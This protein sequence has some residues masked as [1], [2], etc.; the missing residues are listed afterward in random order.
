MD[1]TMKDAGSGVTDTR[2]LIL[3]GDDNVAV[4]LDEIPANETIRVCGV[5]VVVVTNLQ[6]GHKIANRSINSGEKVIKYGVPIG[7]AT[8]EIPIGN[9]V[10]VH[11]IKSDYTNTYVIKNHGIR[12][13]GAGEE[14]K[15]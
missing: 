12:V 4:V 14:K 13:S 7:T 3:S 6:M 5:D 1:D 2:L 11:N 9:H 10:H 8:A 15:T